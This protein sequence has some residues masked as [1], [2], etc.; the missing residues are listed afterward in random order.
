MI[1][2]GASSIDR[3]FNVEKLALAWL[4]ERG[5]TLVE[6]NYRCKMGEIDIIMHD[7]DQLVFV[8]VRFRKQ[9]KFGSAAESVNVKKQNKLIKAAASFLATHPRYTHLPCRFDVLAANPGQQRDKLSWLW[10]K[11]AFTA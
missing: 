1:R 6:Q 7:I 5:L 4:C 8:E 9:I 10:I 2:R 3:G 11:D